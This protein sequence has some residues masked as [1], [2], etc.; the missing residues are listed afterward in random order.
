MAAIQNTSFMNRYMHHP[1][2]AI[3]LSAVVIMAAG[4]AARDKTVVQGKPGQGIQEFRQ[5]T[6][7][8]DKAVEA[9]LQALE[10]VSAA[11]PTCPPDVTAALSKEVERLEVDSLQV[12]AHA[13]ALLARGDA[14]FANWQEQMTAVRDPQVR[15]LAQEHRQALETCFGR[16]KEM[17]GQTR[18][19]FRPFLSGLRRLRASLEQDPGAVGSGPAKEWIGTTRE[20]G[21]QVRQ[22]FAAILR[23]LDAMTQ[24]ITP[25]KP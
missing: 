6:C 1:A 21:R 12:R 2:A 3:L 18:T 25:V 14:Y 5:M 13:Q 23:E 17:C 11:T 8:A 16:V 20:Q 4:C 15:A 19:S 10:R 7:S 9:A 24:L 22:S